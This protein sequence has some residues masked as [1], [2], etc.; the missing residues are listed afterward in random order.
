MLRINAATAHHI[1]GDLTLASK[2]FDKIFTRIN[3]PPRW[4]ARNISLA[5]EWINTPTSSYHH[6]NPNWKE[7]DIEQLIVSSKCDH[8]LYTCSDLVCTCACCHYQCPTHSPD[9]Y[10]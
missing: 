4:L 3:G 5:F 6:Y 9:Y 2:Y 8:P 1:N 7:E 10:L